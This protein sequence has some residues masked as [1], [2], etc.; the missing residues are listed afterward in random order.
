MLV[1]GLRRRYF[2]IISIVLS[3]V[4]IATISLHTFFLKKERLALIDQQV[5]EAAVVLIESD[6]GELRTPDIHK[7]EDIISEELG[8]NRIGKFFIIRKN[9]GEVIFKSSSA[10]LLPFDNIPQDDQWIT[11]KTTDKL[12]RVLN[13][14]VPR[15]PDRTL[16][17]GLVIDS[18]MVTQTPFTSESLLFFIAELLL[19]LIVALFLTTT[20]L[21]P[22]QQLTSF[23][24]KASDAAGNTTLLPQIPAPLKPDHTDHNEDEFK[25]LV[26][27]LDTL[28]TQVNKGYN[29]FRHWTYQMAHELKTPSS[30]ISIILED[31]VAKNKVG[32]QV[33]QQIS[34]E[35]SRINNTITAFLSWA[36]LENSQKPNQLHANKISYVLADISEQ[37]QVRFP[38]RLSLSFEEDFYVFANPHHL[39][40]SLRNIINNAL[41]YS[42]NDKCVTV[43]VKQNTVQ[44]KDLGQ[45]ISQEVL[46]RLGEPFN[47]GKITPDSKGHHGLG[48]AWVC[49]VAKLY[50]WKLRIQSQAI[51]TTIEIDFKEENCAP[52]I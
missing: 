32:E 44:I 37:M 47:R 26:T 42:P 40:Q 1:T 52:E 43:H 39:E 31:A 3:I 24:K 19:G 20:F 14:K 8:E 34:N 9:T 10:S 48:L 25:N 28:I 29:N 2:I 22:V 12:I 5:R 13:L 4:T 11:L 17:V 15:I 45:G 30:M 36:E 35:L 38:N 41:H 33:N 21:K 18:K 16:Q 6:L 23:I 51:G 27:S 46:N 7:A 50:N 49:S